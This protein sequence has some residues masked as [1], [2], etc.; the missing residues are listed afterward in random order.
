MRLVSFVFILF[1]CVSCATHDG[2]FR[3]PASHITDV[4]YGDHDPEKSSVRE[5]PPQFEPGFVRHFYFIE[6]RDAMG[7]HVDRDLHEFEIKLGKKSLEKKIKRVLR[8]RFYLI[9]ETKKHHTGNVDFY[10]DGS[11]L[12]QT[13]KLDIIQPDSEMTFMRKLK[14][15]NSRA[16]LELVL[17]DKF[18]KPIDT[19]EA[20]EIIV[21]GFGVRNLVRMGNGI[22]HF[23]LEYPPGNQLFYISLRSQGAYFKNLF[24]FQYVDH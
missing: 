16:K 3:N 7:K 22:W 1:V 15:R 4:H 20:P 13:F 12:Q 14:A 9:L 2:K 21:E 10:V 24:R 8:G 19:M 5:F 6:L 23:E 11:K 17:R 18:G